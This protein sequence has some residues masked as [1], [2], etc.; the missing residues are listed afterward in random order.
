MMTFMLSKASRHTLESSWG[1]VLAAG[2]KPEKHLQCVEAS[3]LL[4]VGGKVDFS[5]TFLLIC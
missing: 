3:H 4:L 5:R 1:D 2:F